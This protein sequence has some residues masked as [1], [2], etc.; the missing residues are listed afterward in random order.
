MRNILLSSLL[1][2]LV[3]C[4]G[5]VNSDTGVTPFASVSPNGGMLLVGD[6]KALFIDG[7]DSRVAATHFTTAKQGESSR[8]SGGTSASGTAIACSSRETFLFNPARSK[9]SP[10]GSWTN[11]TNNGNK[12]D[13]ICAMSSDGHFAVLFRKSQ[14][15]FIDGG[16]DDISLTSLALQPSDKM[17]LVAAGSSFLIL[18]SNGKGIRGD[19]RAPF[20]TTLF[21]HPY[22]A[23]AWAD[24][25][26]F[27]ASA[28]VL[29][30]V[31]SYQVQTASLKNLDSSINNSSSIFQLSPSRISINPCNDLETCVPFVSNVDDSWSVSGTWGHYVGQGSS[32]TRLKLPNAA[33][34]KS[35][36]AFAHQSLGG[37]FVYLGNDDG[38][39]GYLDKPSFGREDVGDFVTTVARFNFSVPVIESP[40]TLFAN[41]SAMTDSWWVSFLKVQRA[42]RL[43]EESQITPA[44]VKIGYVDSGALMT[45][46]GLVESLLAKNGEIPNNLLDDEDDGYVDDASGYDYVQENGLVL[47]LF[48]H[49]THVAGL[50]VGKDAAPA[51]RNG[52]LAVIRALDGAGKSTSLD[53]ARALYYA[54]SLDV[55]VLNLSWGGGGV[56]RALRDAFAA[57][58]EAG[59]VV[60]SS[61][62][63]DGSSNDPPNIPEVPKNFPGVIGVGAIT[64]GSSLASYSNYGGKSVMFLTPGDKILSTIKTGDYG[65]LS[66]TSMA[67]PVA[68]SCFSYILGLAKERCSKVACKKTRKQLQ[69]LA[70]ESL[71]KTADSRTLPGKSICGI[72]NLEMATKYILEASL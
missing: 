60:F 72:I 47:D 3:S 24:N 63:N 70:L 31:D 37:K 51:C 33:N 39:F 59:I 6:L 50:L 32:F 14:R 67:S 20:K 8:Y 40:L 56:T 21:S 19:A 17:D 46:P 42:W 49:G 18:A 30:K 23:G 48:G 12:D 58:A 28:S 13:R 2:N 11:V 52:Q 44:S 69:D 5:P 61:A 55:E 41:A 9:A 27:S 57:V 38:D 34:G 65:E 7:K 26:R 4:N 25:T 1:I 64:S 71:C 43:A 29:V 22:N 53:L 54:I 68:A 10:A 62:G 15:L 36:V 35:G 66:G 16:K 45:H